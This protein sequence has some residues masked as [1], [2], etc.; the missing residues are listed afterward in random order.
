M[1]TATETQNVTLSIPKDVLKE[2]KLIAVE[3]GLSMSGLMTQ[4][5]RELIERR[6]RYQLAQQ[7]QIAL[8]E[9][10]LDLGTGGQ[11]T[12][13]RDSLHER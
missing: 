8:M 9:A 3:E 1:S 4:M 5:L 6:S 2:I 10:G 11:I 12:W 13:T 7:R